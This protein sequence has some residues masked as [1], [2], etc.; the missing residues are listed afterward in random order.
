MDSQVTLAE[1]VELGAVDPE[2]FG[3]FF[4]PK[5]CRQRSPDFHHDMDTLLDSSEEE[6]RYIAFMIARGFAKTTKVRLY[7]ARRLSYRV[8]RTVVIVGKSQEAAAKTLEWVK[9]AVMFNTRWAQAFGIKQGSIWTATDIEVD[10]YTYDEKGEVTEKITVRIMALGMTGSLRGINIDDFRP[11]LIIADDP[12]D[13]ENTAT[14]EQRKKMLDLFFGALQKTLA[15]RVDSEFAKMVLLQT[16]INGEDL[17]SLCCKD[18][19][20]KSLKFSC[21]KVLPDGTVVSRWEERFPTKALLLEKEGHI[22]KNILPLWLREM[23]C[24]VVSEE[25]AC[26]GEKWLQYYDVLPL[27]GKRCLCVD[28]TP[29]PREGEKSLNKK[30]DDAVIMAMQMTKGKFY[31]LEYVTFKSPDPVEFILAMFDMARKWKIKL[32]GFET[33]LFQRVLAFMFKQQMRNEK[34]WLTVKEIEDRRNKRVRIQQDISGV[35]QQ[36]DLYIRP[37]MHQLRQQFIEFPEV[38]HDDLLDVVSIGINTLS[39][40]QIEEVDDYIDGEYEVLDPED[41]EGRIAWQRGAP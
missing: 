23:E 18:P 2:F 36:G 31:V 33:V 40:Y 6:D 37:E 41:P 10:L 26:F 19:Q 38:N 30:L 8:S 35:A 27:G 34:F 3:M 16:V 1:A 17:I 39:K 7:L 12:C 20:W 22:E 13:D 4:F 32:C 25:T 29:P 9:R 5:A 24:K 11:D 21:F 28:P 15:P 14:P